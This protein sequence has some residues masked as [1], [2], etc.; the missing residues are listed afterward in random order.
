MNDSNIRMA[1]L[2]DAF[3]ILEIYEPY[4]LNT[5]VTFEYDPVPINVFQKRMESIMKQFPWLVY[6]VEGVI[7]GYAYCCPFHERAAF[8]WDCEC[9]VYI[10]TKYQGNG[11]G[12]LLYK[13]L[14][15]LV[16]AQGYYN[17]YALI[18]T[19]NESS[20]RFHEKWGFQ[21]DGNHKNCGYKFGEWHGLTFMSKQIRDLNTT[22]ILV[23]SI[24]EI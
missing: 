14:F 16:E 12:S 11:I 23:K 17:I 9:S 15:Q 20:I 3:R 6:E 21:I 10:D 4:I 7:Q 19:S 24:H 22:P 8:A 1:T 5:A 18:T 2:E 13:K